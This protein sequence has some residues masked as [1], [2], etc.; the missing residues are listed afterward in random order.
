MAADGSA[1]TDD[2]LEQ[3]AGGTTPACVVSAY[4]GSAAVSAA[5]VTIFD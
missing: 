3:A 5:A 1:L 4:V 2:Q